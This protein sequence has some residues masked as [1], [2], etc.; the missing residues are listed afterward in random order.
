MCIR[1]RTNAPDGLQLLKDPITVQV[2]LR[3]TEQQIV[4][5]GIDRSKCVYDPYENIYYI[6]DL[7]YE[8]N[9]DV[10]PEMPVTGMTDSLW[11]WMPLLAGG[12]LF[13]GTALAVIRKKRR[14][15]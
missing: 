6:F 5:N 10:I 11:T 15:A 9:N 13:V 14:N 12:V 8:V 2:P 4:E 7:T 3:V 1:D